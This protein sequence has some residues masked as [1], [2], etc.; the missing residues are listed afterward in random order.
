MTNLDSVL[1]HRDITLPAKVHIVKTIVFLGSPGGSDGKESTSNAGDLGLIPGLEISPE[2][3]IA[4]HFSFL[5]W[6]TPWRSLAG[7][8]LQRVG[9]T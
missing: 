5:A 7:L 6:R 3:G 9:H 8:R 2:K 1:R 4:A